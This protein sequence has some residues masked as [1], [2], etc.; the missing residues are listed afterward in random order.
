MKAKLFAAAVIVLTASLAAQAQISADVL[1]SHNLSPGSPSPVTGTISAPCLYCHAPHSGIGATLPVPLWSQKLSSVQSYQVYTSSTMVNQTN[2]SPP[3]GSDSTLC[4]SCH[5]GTVAPGTLQPWGQVPMVGSM[6]ASDV[7]GTNLQTVHPFS[8]VLPLK[9]NPADLVPSLTANPP[10]TADTTGAVTLINGNVEC[11]SCHNPHVQNI[12]PNS[13]FLVINNSSSALCLACHSTI[14][15]GTGMGMAVSAAQSVRTTGTQ[16]SGRL[17]DHANPLEG[18]KTGV[19]ATASNRVAAQ[20]SAGAF[21]GAMETVE[22]RVT[23]GPYSTVAQNGCLS[24]HTSHN[25]KSPASLLR[26][27]SDQACIVCHAGNSNVSP[28]APNILAEMSLPKIGHVLPEETHPHLANESALLNQNRHATC[29]DCHNAH[30]SSRVPVFGGAPGMRPS[31]GRVVGISAVD[32]V[33]ILNPAVN[34]YENCLRCHGSSTGKVVSAT[35]GYAPMRAVSTGDPLNVIPQFSAI[36]TSSHPV[37]HDRS[38]PFP[39]PS[40]RPN[41]LNLDGSTPGRSMGVRVLCTD[42]HNSDDNREFGGRGPNGPHGSTFA[43]ILERRYEFSQAPAPGQLITNLFQSP[44]TSA[45]GGVN[46]GPYA[47]CAK[48]HDLTRVL[49]NTSFS[50]HARHIKDG[51]SCSVCHTAHGMGSQSGNGSGERLMNFDLSVVAPNGATPIRYSR[52]SNSCS[53][54]C[55]GVAHKLAGTAP[56]KPGAPKGR[57]Q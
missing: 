14:P 31:Q 22:K 26:A 45:A 47:L 48:C 37:M 11:T 2:P 34:Q 19:H 10:S 52:A 30:S 20:I 9:A 28:A 46:G 35:F 29:V 4:L 56:A 39:Q 42:C 27:S 33:S 18:W 1:G 41:M 54:V 12:D 44:N 36:A 17:S 23:L 57:A 43:H 49:G 38:S 55:H 7:L 51:F 3:L 16:V 13:S 24:C 21:P 32:G 53:L 5:D 40:L 6:N 25:A 50:Q 8:F 15:S